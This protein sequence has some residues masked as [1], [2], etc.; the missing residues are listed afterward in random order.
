MYITSLLLTEVVP[1]TT[2]STERWV[3]FAL[4]ETG[5]QYQAQDTGTTRALNTRF[6]IPAT[7]L[8]IPEWHK[9]RNFDIS[10]LQLGKVNVRA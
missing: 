2:E 7:T 3:L 8:S 4:K 5:R 9:T 10:F 6:G 1:V